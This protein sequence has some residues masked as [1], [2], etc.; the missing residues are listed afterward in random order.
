[1]PFVWKRILG[2][3]PSLIGIVVITFLLSR[4]LPGD[5]AAHLAGSAA[6]ADAIAQI[7]AQLELDKSLIDQFFRYLVDLAH[8]NLGLSLTTGQPVLHDLATR[9]P[10]SLELGA[11]ALLFGLGLAVPLGVLAA[12][13]PE[14][15]VD[16]LCRGSSA[17]GSAVPVF[18]GGL[19]LIYV[20]HAL[21]GVL[22]RP[23]SAPAVMGSTVVDSLFAR[24]WVAFRSSVGRLVLPSML[25]GL[26]ALAPLAR[27]LH[28]AMQRALGSDFIRTARAGGLGAR[29]ILYAYALR[30]ALLPLT[31][32]LGGV[33]GLLLGAGVLVEPVFGWPGVG[34]YAASAVLASDHAAVQG[35]VLMTAL[36]Y[37]LLNLAIEIARVALDPRV[38]FEG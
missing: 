2:T 36:L 11:C 12:S 7:R 19:L 26:L 34:A 17:V 22:P 29:K 27:T 14:P 9:L 1:M 24:E 10:A 6:S 4:A 13:P 35:F 37:V 23:S 8:G 38:R 20:F 15:W 32:G 30:N 3:V 21:F 5:A 31:Q 18:V 33:L 25:L 16:A 28:G